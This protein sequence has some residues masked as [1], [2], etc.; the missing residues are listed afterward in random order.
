M[1]EIF[2]FG[3]RFSLEPI[4]IMPLSNSE[5]PMPAAIA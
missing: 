1:Q 3:G 4:H 2:I 5:Q